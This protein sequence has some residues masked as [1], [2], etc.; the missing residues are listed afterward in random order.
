MQ[1]FHEFL[2]ELVQRFFPS[3][4]LNDVATRESLPLEF[5]NREKA[6][7]AQIALVL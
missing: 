5:S 3:S 4:S 1:D 2:H 6:V 7:L